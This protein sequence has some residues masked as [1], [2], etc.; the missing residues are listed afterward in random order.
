[1]PIERDGMYGSEEY[2]GYWVTLDGRLWSDRTSR[3][4]SPIKMGAYTGVQI[5]NRDNL[6]VKRYMH[7]LILEIMTGIAPAGMHACHN[8][9]NKDDNRYENL[10]WATPVENNSDKLI[11]GT[12]GSGE[13]NG[14]AKLTWDLVEE[15]RI[16]RS[17]GA[18]QN[19]LCKQYGVSPMTIS[20]IVRRQL[21]NKI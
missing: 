12:A 1:M 16:L 4:L 14:M 13:R 17:M 18:V 2:P 3:F 19:H 7:R 6:L 11:H 9:G 21:W 8:N 15:I 5:K 20:R 10:R